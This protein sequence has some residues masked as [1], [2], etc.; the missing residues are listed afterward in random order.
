MTQEWNLGLLRYRWVLYRLS[1]QRSPYWLN[2]SSNIFSFSNLFLKFFIQVLKVTFHLQLLQNI[3][4]QLYYC[5]F[6]VIWESYFFS[7]HFRPVFQCYHSS[8]NPWTEEPEEPCSP[9][10]CKR[11]RFNL[12]TKQQL[13]RKPPENWGF[14]EN[15]AKCIPAFLSLLSNGDDSQHNKCAFIYKYVR[16]RGE[17]IAVSK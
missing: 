11:V 3:G 17:R 16:W 1:R 2:I 6:L 8:R 7:T 5:F 13:K 12:A 9:W 4:Y 14:S 10:G 15:K